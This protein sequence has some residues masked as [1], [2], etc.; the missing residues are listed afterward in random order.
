MGG[1]WEVMW[2]LWGSWEV[3]EGSWEVSGVSWEVSQW[4]WEVKGGS[5]QVTRRLQNAHCQRYSR[6]EALPVIFWLRY[7]SQIWVQWRPKKCVF[8]TKWISRQKRVFVPLKHGEEN[9]L[10]HLMLQKNNTYKYPWIFPHLPANHVL[11]HES[12]EVLL[13]SPF[14]LQNNTFGIRL[15]CLT[16]VCYLKLKKLRYLDKLR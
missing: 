14:L 16:K 7:L 3:S 9:F 13:Y 2:G 5:R 12:K 15:R 6:A 8:A 4:S 11:A 10:Q 1:Q